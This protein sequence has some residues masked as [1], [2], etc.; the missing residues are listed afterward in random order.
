MKKMIFINIIIIIAIQTLSARVSCKQFKKYEDAK[1]YL[2]A[3]KHGYRSLDRNHDGIP[4]QKLYKASLK[5]PQAKVRI[6]H[7]KDGHPINFYGKRFTTLKE[8]RIVQSSLNKSHTWSNDS[9]KCE[10][11]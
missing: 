1:A 10:E 5:K 3:K 9:Y 8:C 6:R 2:D 7:Y 11:V 4:C